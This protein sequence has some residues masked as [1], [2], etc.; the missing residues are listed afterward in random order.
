MIRKITPEQEV[1]IC[2][3]YL[4]MSAAELGSMFGHP[5]GS[6]Q[7]CWR[8]NGIKIPASVAKERKAIAV[9]SYRAKVNAAADPRDEVIKAEYLNIPIKALAVKINKSHCWLNHRMKVLGLVVPPEI[10]ERNRQA[11]RRKPGDVSFN[12]GKKQSEY[13]SAE[14]IERTKGTRFQ[15][16]QTSAR[17][18]GFKNG[19]ISVRT[20]KRT[21]L[22]YQWVRVAKGKWTHYHC[23]VWEQANGKIPEGH[24]ITFKDGNQMNA[25]LE[26]LEMISMQDNMRRNSGVVNLPD[27][28]IAYLITGKFYKNIKEDVKQIP[29]LLDL[30]RA[31]VI[32]KRKKNQQDGKP[33]K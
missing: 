8:R 5:K 16:G 3:N 9:R 26:N 32:I 28:Y 24:V 25:V 6:I 31:S 7:S 18:H 4:T 14:Q 17:W 12:K 27:N 22:S 29:E 33:N 15:P 1:F 10:I 19:D 20:D 13:M 2:S 11:G 21:G 23:W 30:K